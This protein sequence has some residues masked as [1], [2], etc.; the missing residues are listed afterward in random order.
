MYTILHIATRNGKRID[1][2]RHPHN[3]RHVGSTPGT[4]ST[5]TVAKAPVLG[6][7]SGAHDDQMLG[8][9]SSAVCVA[10]LLVLLSE[11]RDS[12]TFLGGSDVTNSGNF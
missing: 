8:D 11:V 5:R 6:T 4:D 2:F 9:W 1:I 10:V 12:N 3:P 7:S